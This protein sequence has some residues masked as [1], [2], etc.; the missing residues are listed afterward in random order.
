VRLGVVPEGLTEWLA[1]RLNRVPTPLVDGVF[2]MMAC[3]ALMAGLELGLIDQLASGPASADE[4]A[5]RRGL[6]PVGTLALA[7]ALASGG[8][9]ERDGSRYRL[10]RRARHW[11]DPRIGDNRRV[12]LVG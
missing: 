4:L 8:Y 11:L 6:D 5:E 12:A 7:K 3:R 9:L 2:A 1:L 10:A